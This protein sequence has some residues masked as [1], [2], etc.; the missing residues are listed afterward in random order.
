MLSGSKAK[1]GFYQSLLKTISPKA[2]VIDCCKGQFWM[3]MKS[4]QEGGAG[5]AHFFSNQEPKGALTIKD[6]KGQKLKDLAQL[7][8]SW[9]FHEA[10]IGLAAINCSMSADYA[11]GKFAGNLTS[12]NA[13]ELF[14]KKVKNRKV[15]VIGHFPHL[16]KMTQ[17]AKELY[18]LERSPQNGDLPDTAAEYILPSRQMVFMTGSSII[19]KSA[20]RLIELSQGAEIYLVGPSVP[21]CPGLFKYGLTVLAGSIISDY[22]ALAENLKDKC[23]VDFNKKFTLQVNLSPPKSA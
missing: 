3:L 19:N 1:W 5:L 16:D 17:T 22:E 21:L 9:D 7:V 23:A 10:S 12:G 4:D 20:P 15:A 8:K 11:A 18:I 2:R 14:L 6:I 13:F